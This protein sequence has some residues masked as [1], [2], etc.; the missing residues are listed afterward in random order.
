MHWFLSLDESLFRFVNT[1]L[2]NPACDWLMPRLASNALFIPAL[3]LACALLVWRGGARARVFVVLLLVTLAVGDGVVCNSLKHLVGRLRPFAALANTRTLI[4]FGGAETG[5]PSAHAANWFAAVM[6]CALYY[7]R[8]VKIVAPFA[9]IIAFSR[10]Y[11]GVHFPS[12][13]LGGAL[14]GAGTAAAVAVGANALWSFI[15]ARWFPAEWKRMPS[16]LHPVVQPTTEKLE[17]A[18]SADGCE[19]R[20][21]VIAGYALIAV[22]LVARLLYLASGRIELSE[23]E[24][25]QWLWSKHLAL[26]YYSKPPLIALT[27]F[28]GTS[29]W[30]DTAFG[31]RFF[32]P[33][34]AAALSLMVLRFV[35]R[36]A[37]ARAAF[38]LVAI[39]HATPM[40][41]AGAIL[42]TIDPLSVL[43][44]TAAMIAGWRAVKSDST[45]QWLLCGLWMGL[46]FLSKY[47]ALFQLLSWAVF[48]ALHPP[49][50]AQLRRPGPWLAL[51]VNA[52][53][54]LPVLI[55]NAQH[56]W[57][58]LGHLANRGGLDQPWQFAPKFLFEFLGAELGLL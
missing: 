19:Q 2:A 35:A 51:G 4:G 56:S 12:D 39:L 21:Y 48:F 24:A 27:Q 20:N 10:V 47:V 33:V 41:A 45:A 28:L 52:L 15:G 1:S 26:S 46:G 8:W 22:V 43:F 13:V 7:R 25:Y 38:W 5:F 18:H 58:T 34:L 6:L 32:S 44:W 3:L 30:G 37:N 31:V 53:C 50:R 57:S 49:A 54:T 36:E 14:L 42:M 23:D 11:N 55:W 40:L 9:V 29:I 17:R 16:L